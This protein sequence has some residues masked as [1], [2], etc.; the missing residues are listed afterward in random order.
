VS[1]IQI[2]QFGFPLL[3]SLN[4]GGQALRSLEIYEYD[5]TTVEIDVKKPHWGQWFGDGLTG[6]KNLFSFALN[7]EDLEDVII[8]GNSEAMIEINNLMHG[9]IEF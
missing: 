7:L 4:V 2:V 8:F 1:A 5:E 3:S 6:F 9:C